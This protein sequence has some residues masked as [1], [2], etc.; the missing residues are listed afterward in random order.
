LSVS[1]LRE[2]RELE[3]LVEGVCSMMRWWRK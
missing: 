2:G 3:L 1:V